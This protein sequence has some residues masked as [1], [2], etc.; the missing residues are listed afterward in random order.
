MVGADQLRTF[1]TDTLA[2]REPRLPRSNQIRELPFH[3]L[4]WKEFELLVLDIIDAR[5]E[6]D[7]ASLYGVEGSSQEGIDIY[8]PLTTGGYD[9]IQCKKVKDF[10]PSKIKE[11]IDLFLGKRED[12]SP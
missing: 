10:G 9:V 8:A 7:G 11:M 3:D 12:G 1:L 4:T 6:V 2:R 5:E